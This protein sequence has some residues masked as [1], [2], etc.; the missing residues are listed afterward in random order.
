MELRS[1][2]RCLQAAKTATA[3]GV[4]VEGF[5]AALRGPV[6]FADSVAKIEVTVRIYEREIEIFA[7]GDGEFLRRHDKDRPA[8]R[9]ACSRD[10][11]LTGQT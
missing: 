2:I 11:R 10:L 6:T 8:L 1:L 4:E 9:A 5:E 7:P 3:C